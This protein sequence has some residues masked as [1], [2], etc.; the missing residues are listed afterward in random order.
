MELFPAHIVEIPVMELRKLEHQVFVRLGSR[1]ES[2][3]AKIARALDHVAVQIPYLGWGVAVAEEPGHQRVVHVALVLI[4]KILVGPSYGAG[5]FY[6]LV[7][8]E[9]SG[10]TEIEF[11]FFVLEDVLSRGI[12]VWQ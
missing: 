12:D 10:A 8:D 2:D 6:T 7:H 3:A 1:I 9:F 11:G 4:K 5:L